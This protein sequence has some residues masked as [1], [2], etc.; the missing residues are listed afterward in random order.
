MPSTPEHPAPAGRD[1]DFTRRLH[2]VVAAH[3]E[4]D[5]DDLKDHLDLADDLCMDSLAAA[6]LLV[7]IEEDMG[8]ALDANLLAGREHVTYG[9][10]KRL[11]SERAPVA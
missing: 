7:V 2:G 8:I 3:L 10:L 6:E 9:E 5:P 4:V 1:D 11:V